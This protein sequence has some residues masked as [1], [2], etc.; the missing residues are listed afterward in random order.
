[1]PMGRA[2]ATAGPMG[3]GNR[4]VDGWGRQVIKK[5]AGESKDIWWTAGER[6]VRGDEAKW[7]GAGPGTREIDR[8]TVKPIYIRFYCL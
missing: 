4:C 3:S 8:N 7:A 6:R 1:M 2:Q 5:K